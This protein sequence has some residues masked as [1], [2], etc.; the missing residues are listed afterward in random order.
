MKKYLPLQCDEKTVMVTEVRAVPFNC[1]GLPATFRINPVGMVDVATLDVCCFINQQFEA[2]VGQECCQ[3]I[4]RFPHVADVEISG[5]QCWLVHFNVVQ[6]M[7]NQVLHSAIS[8]SVDVEELNFIRF[9][10]N[11]MQKGGLTHLKLRFTY[12]CVN[13]MMDLFTRV[14]A[15]SFASSNLDE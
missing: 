1:R 13:L 6:K 5:D 4:L 11:F 8:G 12:Y 14:G 3:S 2:H 15:N 10:T 7:I 9:I